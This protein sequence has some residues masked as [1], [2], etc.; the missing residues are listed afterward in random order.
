[1]G[2]RVLGS[3]PKP[4]ARSHP[5]ISF[6]VT[7]AG[8]RRGSVTADSFIMMR[9]IDLGHEAK[10]DGPVYRNRAECLKMC[11]HPEYWFLTMPWLLMES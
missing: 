2:K 6:R 7:T 8:D 5:S 3:G 10:C 4:I 11:S 1:M 9:D